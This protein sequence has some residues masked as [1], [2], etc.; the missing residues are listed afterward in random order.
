MNGQYIRSID[1]Q[2]ISGEGTFLRLSRGDLKE[3]TEREVTAAQDQAVQTK[4]HVTKILQ[5]ETD[6]KCRLCHQL[7]ETVAKERHIKD[8]ILC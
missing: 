3:E 1:R 2:I 6:S 5:T 8:M 4:Y 7:D